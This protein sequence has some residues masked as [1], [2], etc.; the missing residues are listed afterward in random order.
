MDLKT[1]QIT[2]TA[3]L[4]IL[5][6]ENG[7]SFKPIA[8]TTTNAD[9][10]STSLIPGLVTTE[11]KAQKKNDVK[12]RSML[13]MTLPNE[14]IM[15]FN[16][17]KDVK[18]LF[19]SIQT[20][21]G[22]NEAIKKLQKIVSQ[23][24]I[25]GENISQEDLNLKFLRSLSSEWNTHVVVWRN[26]PDLDTISFDDLNNNFKIV[27]Q[28]VKGTASSSSSSS[29]S[30]HN[31]AF[32]SSSSN[33]NKVN[34]TYGV[35]TANTQVSPASTQV[36]TA[37][38]QVST[39]NLSDDTLALLSMRTRRFFQKT[40]RKITI[41]E[42]DTAGY[43]KNQDSSR[44]TVN[45]EET[46]SKAMVAIDG[47]GFDWSYMAD[48]EV[49][50]NMALMAF[51]DSEVHNDKTCSKT[52]LKSFETLKTQLDDL[53]IEF[54]KSEFNLATYK[55]GLA[56]VEEQLVFY[57]KN[58]VIFCE[59]LAVLKRDIS[60]KDSEISM[61]KSELEKLKQEKESN[62]LKIENFD[63]ASKSLDKLIGSQITDKSRKGVGFV[64]YN[65]VPPPHTGK[66]VSKDISNEVRE[67]PDAPLVKELVSDDKLEKKTVFPTVAKI[68]FVRPKQQ[69]KPVRK[70]VKYAEMYRSQSPRGNQRNWNNQKSQQLGSDFVMYNKACFVCGSFNHVQANCNYHQ[71]E[72]VVY[73]NNYTRVNYNYFSKKAHLSAHR[74]MV[75]R[76][77]L[78][79]TGLR[80]LNT[81]R[82]VN[83]AHPKTTVYSVRPMSHFS[84]SAQSIIK[85]PY[86]TR[87]SL[88]NKNFSQKVNITKGKFYTAR[89]K[90]VNTARPNSSVVNA[91]RANQGHLQKEDQGYVDSGCSR[92]MTGNMSYLSNFKEFDGGYVTFGGG[93]KGG[94][95]T[96]KGTLKTE[97]CSFTDTECFVLSSD[98]KLADKSQVLLKVPRKNNMCSVD[99]KNIVPKE[100]LSCLVAKV[101]LDESMLWHRRLEIA[102]TKPLG[103]S[104]LS[105][106]TRPYELF[107]VEHLSLCFMSP[108]WVSHVT[109]LNTLDYLCKFDGKSDEGFFV[110]YSLNSKAFRVY[111]IRTRKAEENLHIRFLEDKPIIVG[112]GPKWL[113]DIDVLT[114][115]LNY[116]PVVAGT[117]SNNSVGTEE[118]IGT[119]HSSKETESSQDCILMSLWKDG[120]LFDSS[121]KNVSNDEPQPSSDAGKKNDEGICKEN[122]I[123]DQEK[124]ENSTQDVNIVAPSINTEP[125]MFSLGD[126]DTLEATHVDFFGDETEVDM[127]NIT[128]AYPV[129]STPN[130]II[131]KDYSLDHVIG[132]VQSGVLTRRMTKTTNEQGFISAVYEGN[133]YKVLSTCC[134]LVSSKKS[135][136]RNKKDERGIVIRYKA[137]LVV[138][139][140]TQEEGI[141]YD[142]VFAPIARIEAIRLFLAYAS[143]K[144]FVVFRWFLEVKPIIAGDRPNWLFDIDVLTKS[145]NYVP[146]IAGTNSND[147]A[148]TEE[149]I[150]TGHSRKETG[151]SQY[152]ILMPLWKDGSLFDS[153]LKNA[154][155]DEPQPSSDAGKKDDKGVNK[156]SGIDD[157]E[158][159]ENSTQDV[160]T[161]GPS[162]N[163]TST[164]VNTGSLNINTVS[165]T[166]TTAPLE[167]THSDFFVD[168]T[169]IDISNI[170]TTYL[171]PSTPNTRIH[172]DHSLGHAIGDEDL[173]TCLFACFLSQEEPKKVWTLV[174]LPLGKR[175]IG[176]K[177]VYRNKKNERGIVIRNKARLVAPGYTQEE[178][179]DY[180][181]RGQIDKTLFIKRVK[182]DILL[183]Q[184][185]VDEIIFGSTKKEL[186][187]EFEKLM[188]NKF[189]MSSMA[190]TPIETS[191]PLMKDENADDVDVHLYR[192]MIGSLLYLTS[193]R[194]DIMFAVCACARFQVTPKVSHLYAAKRIFRYLKGQ[195]KLGLWYPKDSPF[196]LDSYSDSD[197]VGAS[198][199]RK[200]TTEGCQFLRSKLISWQCKKQTIVANSTTEVE[201]VVAASCCGKVLWIPNQMLD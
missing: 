162:I 111:N 77:V 63:N 83:T 193:S 92:H 106:I 2:T 24:A 20:R 23:L 120:L 169:E 47:A 16:Q 62:Q 186:C 201:Y 41:N 87:T 95:I 12:A 124:S 34:T 158:R 159:P 84:K 128:T 189:Q 1:V 108:F 44:R 136:K 199:D 82:P 65:V 176:T 13:L 89:P 37:S 119:G 149:S 45:V 200:S 127:S 67:S 183:V 54:N 182:S 38:T 39:A 103:I 70:P 164:N 116:V 113:F 69:E 55:R 198:L 52:C 90:V 197:Y 166:I 110:G 145:M 152:Y 163:T 9:G 132:D 75:P 123:A 121:L 19:A 168:E 109:I 97:Q 81:A 61:L 60:Y 73:R 102:N 86:Q 115:S 180:D 35:N 57:K 85:R 64:S 96:S 25:L 53:R 191:K 175:A 10:A 112:N 29:L 133:S 184:V 181:E 26:K 11:E 72:R 100:S 49:P 131:H 51:S 174:D 42:S 157:Q 177:W 94:K 130:T 76:A 117:N 14:H 18:T 40:G 155:N 91:V 151:S 154:S 78:M 142:E 104:C 3:K 33:T 137:R 59:Q 98:F 165:L 74:N 150:G 32:V 146:V 4:P 194:P 107:R 196:D 71:R 68:E 6:Q 17:Y 58:E 172:K 153:S 139:G 79:K 101:T 147:F 36:S 143:F 22:G 185:Y 114:K 195:S 171:V 148:G 167:A 5:K 15:T 126:N 144:D 179:I 118:S 173:H 134:L 8:Q 125:D 160:N 48:D 30:Y 93:A 156:E 190:S 88:T 140:Y 129:S 66:S 7:N 122:R 28:E 192:S 187:T 188:H 99:M 170:N 80:S 135:L 138:Q 56:S 105:I 178:R 31:M 161:D 27:E 21:F 50:T 141:D 43:D 46:S